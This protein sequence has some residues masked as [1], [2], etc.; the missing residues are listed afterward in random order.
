MAVIPG[1]GRHKRRVSGCRARRTSSCAKPGISARA[2]QA[3][4][5]PATGAKAHV[6][7]RA[8]AR[9]LLR[10]SER[11]P[12]PDQRLAKPRSLASSAASLAIHG[13]LLAW[14]VWQPPTKTFGNAGH[15]LDAVSVEM[16]SAA[17]LESLSTKKAG[18]NAS[19]AAPIAERPGSSAPEQ[20]EVAASPDIQPTK[21]P[22]ETSSPAPPPPPGIVAPPDPTP[23]VEADLTASD[24]GPTQPRKPSPEKVPEQKIGEPKPEP[25]P[26]VAPPEKDRT[27]TQPAQAP[28]SAA[29]VAQ[30]ASVSGGA[31]ATAYETGTTKEAAAGAAAGEL[32]RFALE[33]RL[34][35]GRARPRH[36]GARGRALIAFSLSPEGRLVV[37]EIARTSGN[38]DVDAAALASVRAAL[39]PIPPIGSTDTQRTYT[40]PF[41]FK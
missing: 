16:I 40:V 36:G 18:A 11:W 35:L 17:A 31:A 2:I 39:F 30:H 6:E 13:A 25:A 1:G 37:A 3:A 41:E 27:L 32:A 24:A 34:A 12:R 19:S 21:P 7:G 33:V 26:L 29:A 28:P 22:V 5:V 9:S 8:N 20:N 23:D 10:G 38:R 15:E 14:L 4:D